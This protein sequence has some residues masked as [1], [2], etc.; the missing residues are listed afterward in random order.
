[1]NCQIAILNRLRRHQ[2]RELL[3]GAGIMASESRAAGGT[4]YYEFIDPKGSSL[5][6]LPPGSR[7]DVHVGPQPSKHRSSGVT[8]IKVVLRSPVPQTTHALR[9]IAERLL[10]IRTCT[11]CALQAWAAE[12]L[13]TAIFVFLGTGADVAPPRR[14]YAS[15]SQASCSKS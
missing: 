7:I 12:L 15:V 5:A 10:E 1:M 4:R 2:Q 13:G 14:C 11:F 6:G 3:L 8:L 9:D